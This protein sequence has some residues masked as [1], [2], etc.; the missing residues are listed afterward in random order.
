MRQR[1]PHW[2]NDEYDS[3]WERVKAAV[4]RDWDQTKHDF[5]G[6]EPDTDQDVDDTVKQATGNQPI[7]PR[8]QPTF[9]DVEPAHRFGY[10]AYQRYHGEFD[11]WDDDLETRLRE[12]WKTTGASGEDFD[13][14]RPAMQ[15]GW[16]YHEHDKTVR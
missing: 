4:R 12:D 8:G 15:Y 2:W 14:F 7:P 3:T 10:G 9:E 16:E 11:S 13:R 5:G 6:D 1:N